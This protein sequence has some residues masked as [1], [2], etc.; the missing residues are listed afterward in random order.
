MVVK[1]YELGVVCVSNY[2]KQTNTTLS[3]T[4]KRIYPSYFYCTPFSLRLISLAQWKEGWKKKE[5]KQSA[6]LRW[7]CRKLGRQA[8]GRAILL[9]DHSEVRSILEK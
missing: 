6:G 1:R 7:A 3:C 4:H 5:E 2:A 9:T 8:G